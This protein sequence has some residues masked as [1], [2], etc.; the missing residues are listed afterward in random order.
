MSKFKQK[1]VEGVRTEENLRTEQMQLKKKYQIDAERE[2]LIVEKSGLVKLLIQSFGVLIKMM[3]GIVLFCLAL[4]GLAALIY[5]D[6]RTELLYQWY[7][8]IEQFKLLI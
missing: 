7:L 6:T 1:L 4:I 2:V 8:T 3:A 5:P